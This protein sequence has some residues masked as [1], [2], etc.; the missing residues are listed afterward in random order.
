MKIVDMP[1]L[2]IRCTTNLRQDIS[3]YSASNLI[4][5]LI[6][7]NILKVIPQMSLLSTIISWC[8]ESEILETKVAKIG[9]NKYSQMSMIRSIT[10]DVRII[11]M[12]ESLRVMKTLRVQVVI[13]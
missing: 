12:A 1:S 4:K 2:G 3:Y 10:R 11:G 5:T 8:E 6:Q 7:S 9:L 13:Q